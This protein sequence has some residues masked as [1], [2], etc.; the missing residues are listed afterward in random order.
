MQVIQY[1]KYELQYIL[2][3]L[4]SLDL[5]KCKLIA[6]WLS[7]Y[8][9]MQ[10]IDYYEIS[11][12]SIQELNLSPRAEKVL[13]NNNIHTIGSLINRASN[14]DNIRILKG[15]GK[16]VVNELAQKIKEIQKGLVK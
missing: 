1:D 5:P 9:K 7:E 8:I 4:K 16:V 3:A 13:K 2:D 12:K 14:W 10:E 15:A 6:N 11:H